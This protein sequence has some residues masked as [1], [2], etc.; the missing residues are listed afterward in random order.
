MKKSFI[1]VVTGVMSIAA[2]AFIGGATLG[3]IVYAEPT[4]PTLQG[5][6]KRRAEVKLHLLRPTQALRLVIH[7]VKV[8]QLAL[9]G[10]ARLL[11][12][13]ARLLHRRWKVLTQ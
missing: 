6:V 4:L 13:A 5:E 2:L 10:V 12:A 7:L 9:R 11:E 8:V 3:E 1:F